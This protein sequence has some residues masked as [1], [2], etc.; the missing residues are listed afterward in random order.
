MP[1]GRGETPFQSETVAAAVPE[2]RLPAATAEMAAAGVTWVPAET[3][4]DE[5]AGGD[6]HPEDP[7]DEWATDAT[8]PGIRVRAATGILLLLV[9]LAG[10][11][12][13]GAVAEK[14]HVSG[15]TSLASAFASR[16][17]A[18]RGG[19]GGSGSTGFG[20]GGGLFGGTGAGAPATSGLATDVT[21]SVIDVTDSAGASV[22]VRVSPST[23]IIRVS[24]QTAGPIA[25]GDNL[26]VR[27]TKNPDG[28]VAAS[29][30]TAT[31]AGAASP[32]GG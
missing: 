9:A 8:R 26:V 30:I 2:E 17:S 25:I 23:R 3:P 19:T 11:F 18:L 16:L 21:A 4:E 28:S 32:A 10:G 15:S 24:T 1:D 12:W 27:G 20:G 5:A 22:T 14:H 7:D 31:A 13:G 6:I 29:S